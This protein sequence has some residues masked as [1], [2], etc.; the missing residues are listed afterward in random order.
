MNEIQRAAIEREGK[1]YLISVLLGVGRHEKDRA[2]YL[3]GAVSMDDIFTFGLYQ[4]TRKHVLIEDDDRPADV[5]ARACE[6]VGEI[7]KISADEV[8]ARLERVSD[9][10]QRYAKTN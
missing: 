9:A 2:I 10:Y 1:L 4:A 6:L 8:F 3:A 5:S 7:E